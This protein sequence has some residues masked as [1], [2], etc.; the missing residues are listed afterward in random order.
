MPLLLLKLIADVMVWMLPVDACVATCQQ[1]R[2]KVQ[3]RSL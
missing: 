1:P 2:T 3:A